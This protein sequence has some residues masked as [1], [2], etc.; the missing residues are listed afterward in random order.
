MI[1]APTSCYFTALATG[2]GAQALMMEISPGAA[3]D[4]MEVSFLSEDF[5]SDIQALQQLDGTI[6]HVNGVMT[7]D[8]AVEERFNPL[9]I[10][11]KMEEVDELLDIHLRNDGLRFTGFGG[12]PYT[13]KLVDVK[14]DD[15]QLAVFTARYHPFELPLYTDIVEAHDNFRLN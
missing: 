4:I 14:R 6:K 7:G 2:E 13:L 9:Y 12:D 8:L 10:P 15:E 1:K 5:D 3:A 11:S